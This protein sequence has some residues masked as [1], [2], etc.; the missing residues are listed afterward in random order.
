MLSRPTPPDPTLVARQQAYG[1]GAVYAADRQSAENERIHANTTDRDSRLDDGSILL[2]AAAAEDSATQVE[3]VETSP[4]T[5]ATKTNDCEDEAHQVILVALT[6]SGELIA[7][8]L[9]PLA[10][11]SPRRAVD[12]NIAVLWRCKVDDSSISLGMSKVVVP[13]ED[14]EMSTRWKRNKRLTRRILIAGADTVTCLDVDSG[15]IVWVTV[16]RTLNRDTRALPI[17]RQKLLQQSKLRSSGVAESKSVKRGKKR[18][19]SPEH[20]SQAPFIPRLVFN[21][22]NTAGESDSFDS[23]GDRSSG[24]IMSTVGGGR[25]SESDSDTDTDSV[26]EQRRAARNVTITAICTERVGTVDTTRSLLCPVTLMMSDGRVVFCDIET[27]EPMWSCDLTEVPLLNITL[28]ASEGFQS[29]GGS[30]AESGSGSSRSSTNGEDL[31]SQPTQRHSARHSVGSGSMLSIREGMFKPRRVSQAGINWQEWGFVADAPRVCDAVVKPREYNHK[32]GDVLVCRRAAELAGVCTRQQLGLWRRTVEAPV[33]ELIHDVQ[34]I[35]RISEVKIDQVA[36]VGDIV[37]LSTTMGRVLVLNRATGHDLFTIRA[38]TASPIVGFLAPRPSIRRCSAVWAVEETGGL[39]SLDIAARRGVWRVDCTERLLLPPGF[40]RNRKSNE[41]RSDLIKV[42]PSDTTV[43]DCTPHADIEIDNT[44][45][46]ND[47]GCVQASDRSHEWPVVLR[48]PPVKLS[49]EVP[50][51]G[52]SRLSM[53]GLMLLALLVMAHDAAQMIALLLMY[54]SPHHPAALQ[55][56]VYYARLVGSCYW[57]DSTEWK[58]I[59]SDLWLQ[60]A[61]YR[62]FNLLGLAAVGTGCGALWVAPRL[63]TLRLRLPSSILVRGVM[64]LNSLAIFIVYRILPASILVGLA[65]PLS[66]VSVQPPV[67]REIRI[68]LREYPVAYEP[69]FLS[70]TVL[71]NDVNQTCFTSDHLGLAILSILASWLYWMTTVRLLA[72]EFNL[73]RL[74]VRRPVIGSRRDDAPVYMYRH[75]ASITSPRPATMLLYAQYGLAML[76]LVRG[77]VHPIVPAG[78]ALLLTITPHLSLQHKM[79]FFSK[80]SNT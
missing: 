54:F 45:T 75:L 37:V 57:S 19:V 2:Q 24:M 16:K 41:D 25:D 77:L 8:S 66:C 14:L 15:S 10:F 23:V 20:N 12:H 60:P 52:L 44:S 69:E 80:T 55:R 4:G 9:A 17:V 35:G 32:W 26:I 64:S 29:V 5:T 7:W 68:D 49:T 53:I 65:W 67:A 42:T 13:A 46:R 36:T 30:S 78:L 62:H 79:Q 6:A 48:A 11:M 38:A 74:A 1:R 21:S 76:P 31:E 59:D 40:Q 27:G 34:R 28:E 61:N 56:V 22:S 58:P 51:P 72:V 63:A 70:R 18:S 3:T 43:I 47:G 50:A 71:R 33:D 39:V 73:R